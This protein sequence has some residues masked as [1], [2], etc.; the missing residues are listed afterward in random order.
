MC[1]KQMCNKR[2]MHARTNART[3]AQTDAMR[4]SAPNQL[5]RRIARLEPAGIS[6][7]SMAA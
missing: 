5:N 1:N 3:D 4:C 6:A 7:A 2:A